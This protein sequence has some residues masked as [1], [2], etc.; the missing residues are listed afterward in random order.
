MARV[1]A[2]VAAAAAAGA[3]LAASAQTDAASATSLDREALVKRIAGTEG[4]YVNSRG[5]LLRW[6][7]DAD[8]TALVTRFADARFS[9]SHSKTA[10]AEWSVDAGGNYCL[11]VH[12]PAETQHWCAA[13]TPGDDGA[14]HTTAP[15]G[16]A[17][18]LK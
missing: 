7:N 4:S 10:Q 3:P 1:V 16:F 9:K 17:V 8:G 12:W 11:T 13:V 14:L 18:T 2:G 6:K 5:L 15:G